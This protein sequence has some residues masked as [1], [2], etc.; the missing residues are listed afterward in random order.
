MVDKEIQQIKKLELRLRTLQA[1]NQPM[2]KLYSDKISTLREKIKALEE[3]ESKLYLQI[4]ELKLATDK[5]CDACVFNRNKACECDDSV[6]P[7]LIYKD[8]RKN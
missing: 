2:K 5:Y 8:G 4:R 7:K 3:K 6:L 1:K